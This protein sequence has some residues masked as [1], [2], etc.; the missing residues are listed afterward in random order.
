MEISSSFKKLNLDIEN[1]DEIFSDHSIVAVTDS[2]GEIIYANKK[3]CELSKYSEDE[4]MDKVDVGVGY[5]F[6][7]WNNLYIDPNYTMPAKKNEADEREG[8]LNLSVSYKF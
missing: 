1:F 3:F 8:T 7:V 5:S 6:K 4:L 2:E